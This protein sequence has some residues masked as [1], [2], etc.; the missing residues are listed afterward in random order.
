MVKPSGQGLV[1][2]VLQ[3]GQGPFLRVPG[4]AVSV[5]FLV[6]N[7]PFRLNSLKTGYFDEHYIL[8]ILFLMLSI[9]CDKL[10]AMMRFA[11]MDSTCSPVAEK[12]VS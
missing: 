4:S 5:F 9:C 11:S 6:K 7:S 10:P 8:H 3:Q 1:M 2:L 12:S